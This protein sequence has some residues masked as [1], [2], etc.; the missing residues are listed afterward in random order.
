[1]PIIESSAPQSPE[2]PQTSTPPQEPIQSQQEQSPQYND[3]ARKFA[4]LTRKEKDILE[5]SKS[6]E[7][8]YQKRLAELTEKS[9]K[10]KKYEELETTL[11]QDKRKALEFLQQQNISLEDLSSMLIEELNPNEDVKINRKLS[12]YEKKMEQKL[13]N[14][15]KQLL[16][17]EQKAKEDEENQ[18]KSQH[19]K[20][21]QKVLSDITEFVNAGEYPLIQSQQQVQLVYDVIQNHYQEQIDKGTPSQLAQILGFKEASDIV[22]RHLDEELERLY[23]A[24]KPKQK[25]AEA[26]ESNKEASITMTNAHGV[27]D[28]SKVSGTMSREDALKE[29]MKMIRFT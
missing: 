13:A 15:E 2:V 17:R 7:S 11:S 8:E 1:M 24:K 19:E 3:F 23:S 6:Q 27:T 16:E 9:N 22:E 14:L 5:K 4:A 28:A 21:V 20:V 10:Y 12:D 29:A 18:A 25:P 26:S